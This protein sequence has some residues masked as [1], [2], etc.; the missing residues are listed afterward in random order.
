MA[1]VKNLLT[2]EED[3]LFKG[4]SAEDVAEFNQDLDERD[5]RIQVILVFFLMFVI[6]HIL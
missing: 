3:E 2:E 5:V 4:L 1:K 6:Y